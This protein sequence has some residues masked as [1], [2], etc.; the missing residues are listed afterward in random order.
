MVDVDEMALIAAREIEDIFCRSYDGGRCQRL[1]AIQ[2]VVAGTVRD[3]WE[4]RVTMIEK[5]TV[6]ETEAALNRGDDHE[7][8]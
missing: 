6:Q 8:I 7:T 2:K 5:L 4:R 3:V 1:A